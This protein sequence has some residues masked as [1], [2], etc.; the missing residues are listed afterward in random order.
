MVHE[1]VSWLETPGNEDRKATKNRP[2]LRS[3]IALK[4]RGLNSNQRPPGY[5]RQ[6]QTAHRRPPGDP[7]L[8]S[9]TIFG[10]KEPGGL[11]LMNRRPDLSL[12]GQICDPKPL[13]GDDNAVK[14]ILQFQGVKKHCG[15]RFRSDYWN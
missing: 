3:K 15:L 9:L 5:E 10:S 12:E 4:L 8:G 7:I 6:S 1:K 14:S 11:R 13:P 2:A